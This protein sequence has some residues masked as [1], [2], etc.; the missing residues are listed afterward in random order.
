[1]FPVR[2]GSHSETTNSVKARDAACRDE[3]GAPAG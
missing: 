1:V 3:R 2:H